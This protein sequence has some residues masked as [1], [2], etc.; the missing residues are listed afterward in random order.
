V[1]SCTLNGTEQPLLSGSIGYANSVEGDFG[2]FHRD[3]HEIEQSQK[4]S[5]ATSQ[6][7]NF[8]LKCFGVHIEHVDGDQV[9]SGLLEP[10]A[11]CR[12]RDVMPNSEVQITG[13]LNQLAQSVIVMFLGSAVF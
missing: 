2:H 9:R 5:D 8:S 10:A 6:I 1:R 12:S 3:D 11:S 13:I 7:E 4:S